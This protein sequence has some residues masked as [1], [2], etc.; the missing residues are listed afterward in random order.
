ME[1]ERDRVPWARKCFNSTWIRIA[2][3]AESVPPNPFQSSPSMKMRQIG[4][5][6]SKPV[7]PSQTADTARWS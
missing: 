2:Q 1:K 3:L 6:D 5:A 7:P 4:I